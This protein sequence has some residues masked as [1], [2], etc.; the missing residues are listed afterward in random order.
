MRG[1]RHAMTDIVNQDDWIRSWERALLEQKL[2]SKRLTVLKQMV[3]RDRVDSIQ[4]AASI[5]D[6]KDWLMNPDEH[7]Y[8][9]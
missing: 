3:G 6:W 8:G 7:M 9:S 1:E 2:D 4:T 5:L